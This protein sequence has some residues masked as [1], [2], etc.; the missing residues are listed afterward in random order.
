MN[1]LKGTSTKH[2]QIPRE[3]PTRKK[4]FRRGG[5]N[6]SEGTLGS[7]LERRIWLQKRSSEF[8][9]SN[10]RDNNGTRKGLTFSK[11]QGLGNENNRGGGGNIGVWRNVAMVVN[12]PLMNQEQDTEKR[13]EVE[14]HLERAADLKGEP[15]KLRSD[16]IGHQ[17]WLELDL[18][19]KGKA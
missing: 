10:V 14:N 12:W 6:L 4:S 5:N 7:E 3:R 17:I 9:R 2:P 16:Q 19:L 13:K 18:R 15:S 8:S 11:T 1:I